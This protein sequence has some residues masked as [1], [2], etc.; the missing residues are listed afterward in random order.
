MSTSPP[1]PRD[2]GVPGTA[3]EGFRA[4]LQGLRRDTRQVR[5][6]QLVLVVLFLVAWEIAPQQHW[7]NPMLTSY[8]SAVWG[9]FFSLARESNLAHHVAVTLQEAVFGFGMGMGIA[10]LVAVALWWSHFLYRVLDP[11]LVVANAL[12]KIAL[13][14]IFY[15]WLGEV[16]S[17]YGIAIA[18]SVF[19]TILMIYG[20]FR[21]TDADKIKLVRTFG[22]TKWQ[23]LV[24]VVL[25]ANIPTMIGA[26]KINVGLALVGVIAGEFQS[27][28][29]GLGYLIIYGSQILQMHMVMASIAILALISVVMYTLIA[30]LENT[31]VH[32]RR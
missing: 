5:A 12:P 19:I 30:W 16:W 7:V 10:T 25:P 31:V 21:E 8:P 20:G 6:T 22:G 3:S 18:I 24:K 28:K 23:I 13:V 15:V 4:Y 29:A 11:F 1:E 9:M 2:E 26:L 27:S 17:I 32:D 14:P